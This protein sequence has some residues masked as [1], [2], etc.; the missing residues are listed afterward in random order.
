MPPKLPLGGGHGRA[1]YTPFAQSPI[2]F[3]PLQGYSPADVLRLT[4]RTMRIKCPS[5]YTAFFTD[6]PAFR[7]KAALAL[8]AAI[9]RFSKI[10][11]KI[12]D[13]LS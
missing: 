6:F 3:P 5:F 1:Y 8:N 12:L 9:A 4:S 11:K 10:K 7:Y 2:R 13:I